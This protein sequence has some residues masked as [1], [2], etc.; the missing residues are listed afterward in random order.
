MKQTNKSRSF[1]KLPNLVLFVCIKST[2]K[3]L[4]ET[5][6]VVQFFTLLKCQF[7][8]HSNLIF[9]QLNNRLFWKISNHLLWY[10]DLLT[11]VYNCLQIL[12]DLSKCRIPSEKSWYFKKVEIMNY[13]ACVALFLEQ[14]YAVFSSY[15][16]WIL[17]KYSIKF[18]ANFKMIRILLFHLFQDA[19]WCIFRLHS[20]HHSIRLHMPKLTFH[21][22]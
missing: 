20:G 6:K 8:L 3:K 22:K 17:C 21:N 5:L 14:S 11:M 12:K 9:L 13:N 15:L 7:Y 1:V 16:T 19:K 18:Q 4:L 2:N 10:S